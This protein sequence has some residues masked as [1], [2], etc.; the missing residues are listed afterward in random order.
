MGNMQMSASMEGSRTHEVDLIFYVHSIYLI[1][2]V[3][4]LE[5]FYY[6]ITQVGIIRVT[7]SIN[8]TRSKKLGKET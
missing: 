8:K 4:T 3:E 2:R 7:K 6:L 5:T 1:M